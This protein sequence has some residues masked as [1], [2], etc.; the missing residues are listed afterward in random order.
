M[1]IPGDPITP[2]MPGHEI[3]PATPGAGVSVVCMSPATLGAG[4]SVEGISPAKAGIESA[5]TRKNPPQIRRRCF[6]YPP[7]RV[8]YRSKAGL[9]KPCHGESMRSAFNEG[10]RIGPG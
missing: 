7:L 3:S 6:I 10:R 5:S 2:A 4:E 1:L 8:E 9:E